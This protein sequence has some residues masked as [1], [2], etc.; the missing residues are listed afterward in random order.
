MA[1][2]D[3][4]GSH[5]VLDPGVYLM[6]AAIGERA[7]VEALRTAMLGLKLRSSGSKLHWVDES[8][9]RRGEI[10]E[11]IAG[12]PVDGFV[13][14]RRGPDSDR[15]ERRRRKCLEHLLASLAELGCVELVLESRGRV[16]DQ[17]DRAVLDNM[18]RRRML[19]NHIHVSHEVGPAEPVLWIADALCGAVSQ[20]RVGQPQ[21]LKTIERR[22]TVEVIEA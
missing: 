7:S 4:S 1:W 15:S 18:R 8:S 10:A 6:A 14:V 5:A 13:V 16:D 22:V 9:R 20:D 11:V 3:E 17:R 12:L 19:P 21:Y 2:G